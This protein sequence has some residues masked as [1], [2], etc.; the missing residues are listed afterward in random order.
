MPQSLPPF[1]RCLEEDAYHGL[2]HY[3][4][5]VVVTH[6]GGE[7][8]ARPQLVVPAL[9][10]RDAP[11]LHHD[12]VL[13]AVVEVAVEA[14]FLRVVH[15]IAAVSGALRLLDP[16]YAGAAYLIAPSAAHPHQSSILQH[17][18][19]LEMRAGREVE[20]RASL[21]FD[22]L[23]AESDVAPT[24]CDDELLLLPEL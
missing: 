13:I 15:R 23:I 6:P 4:Q 8:I 14:G 3:G 22:D 18:E 9:R 16:E 20:V 5:I 24:S 7:T 2:A 17:I 11:A 21:G 10:Y 19:H 12:P 1:Q